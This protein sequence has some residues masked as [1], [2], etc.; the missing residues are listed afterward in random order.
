MG[1]LLVG[2]RR[3]YGIKGKWEQWV[4]DNLPFDVRTARR[5]ISCYQRKDDLKS[6]T[7]SDSGGWVKSLLPPRKPPEEIADL[8]R[9]GISRDERAAR[10]L[11]KRQ[12]ERAEDSPTV[13]PEID[14]IF[15]A[16][17]QP[18]PEPPTIS[19][20]D[21]DEDELAIVDALRRYFEDTPARRAKVFLCFLRSQ[22]PAICEGSS[23]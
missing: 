4:S 7:V 16:G 6:D 14:P 20:S 15:L 3:S 5:Y 10:R 12:R 13:T 2:I 23:A 11:I 9:T 17:P 8:V 22:F 21:L 18:A 19:E 1:R